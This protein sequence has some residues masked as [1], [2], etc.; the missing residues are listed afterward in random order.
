MG[1]VSGATQP[2]ILSRGHRSLR[3]GPSAKPTAK[4]TLRRRLS[5]TLQPEQQSSKNLLESPG[6]SS[7]TQQV[8]PPISRQSDGDHQAVQPVWADGRRGVDAPEQE[9]DDLPSTSGRDSSMEGTGPSIGARATAAM[10]GA[11]NGR[12]PQ[13]SVLDASKRY[14][15]LFSNKAAAVLDRGSREQFAQLVG[16]HPERVHAMSMQCPCNVHACHACEM[17]PRHTY[18]Y[19]ACS[20]TL[21]FDCLCCAQPMLL[22][23]HSVG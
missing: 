4:V 18:W 6:N 16:L 20:S 22:H 14:P 17:H 13:S 1:P 19:H 10:V 11:A 8:N 9:P 2:H 21:P 15:W 23:N 3:L 12:A 5:T 7:R